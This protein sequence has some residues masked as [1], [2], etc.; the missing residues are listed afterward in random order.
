MFALAA[1][2]ARGA[3]LDDSAHELARKISAN[4]PAAAS[5]ALQFRNESSLTSAE[6]AQVQQT[7]QQDL[8]GRG[9]RP[10]AADSPAYAVSVVFSENLQN[11]VWSAEIHAGDVSGNTSTVVLVDVPRPATPLASSAA[12]PVTLHAEK[13]WE[14]P[15]RILDAAF[16]AAPGGSGRW[17]LLLEPD[18]LAIHKSV[19]GPWTIL[20]FPPSSTY[21]RDPHGSF[22]KLDG[23]IVVLNGETEC[24]MSPDLAIVAKCAP[25][26]EVH[27]GAGPELPAWLASS[28]VGIQSLYAQPPCG[29]WTQWL[30]T[31]TGD[32]T[33]PDYVQAMD[34]RMALLSPQLGFP[35]PVMAL[36]AEPQAGAPWTTVIVRNLK[37][38]NYEAY[39]LSISCNP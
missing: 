28:L 35:G 9:F 29:T 17:L 39:Q 7:V 1:A 32:Y 31:G 38:L 11:L 36:Q 27:I 19:A 8:Q 23:P 6:A 4:L 37:T 3:A 24:T 5:I 13:F 20:P 15:D 21:S 30:V 2:S 33:Q 16:I 22:R 34:S 26:V 18:G 12:L 10:A 14:G 25:F